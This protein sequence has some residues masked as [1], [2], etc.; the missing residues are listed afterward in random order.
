MYA[1]L[2]LSNDGTLLP[3]HRTSLV[4]PLS[5]NEAIQRGQLPKV[6]I[7]TPTVYNSSMRQTICRPF[8]QPQ[9]PPRPWLLALFLVHLRSV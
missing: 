4:V 5:I 3:T 8:H 2:G 1:A 9:D 6:G 7:V